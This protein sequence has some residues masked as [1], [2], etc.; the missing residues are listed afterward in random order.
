MSTFCCDFLVHFNAAG[1]TFH[2]INVIFYIMVE[3]YES[4]TQYVM[5]QI[6]KKYV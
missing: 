5:Y 4:P 2:S 1:K 3:P 6:N